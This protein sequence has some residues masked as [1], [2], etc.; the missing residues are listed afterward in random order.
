MGDND[1]KALA[2][3][4]ATTAVVVSTLFT[5]AVVTNILTSPQ[6]RRLA[7]MPRKQRFAISA[8]IFKIADS[9]DEFD[10]GW[11]IETLRCSKS[12][13]NKIVAMIEDEWEAIHGKSLIITQNSLSVK[14][15][16][17]VY[18]S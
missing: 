5:T 3:I 1:R 4:V 8:S 16:V 12:S 13:F 9:N 17:F 15:L 18:I 11:F 2:A 6:D 10:D 7:P 14:E